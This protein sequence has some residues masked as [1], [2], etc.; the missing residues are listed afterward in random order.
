MQAHPPRRHGADALDARGV[1]A[2]LESEIAKARRC[3]CRLERRRTS[4]RRGLTMWTRLLRL[5]FAAVILAWRCGGGPSPQAFP[6]KPFR[7]IVP[8]P[9]GGATD[10]VARAMQPQLEKISASRWWSR[11]APAPAPSSASTRSPR[12]RPTATPSA[13]ARPAR[14]ASIRRAGEDA[15]RCPQGPRA[16]QRPRGDRRSSSPPRR[17][18][19]PTRCSEVIAHAKAEPGTLTHRSRRQRH[20]DA[21][22]RADCSSPWPT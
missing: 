3:R 21:A 15:V 14:W 17:T 5:A 18:S 4:G 2:F 13:S 22:R 1:R 16:D 20:G 11:T 7:F 8:F 10:A 6:S 19:P 12:P 9:A